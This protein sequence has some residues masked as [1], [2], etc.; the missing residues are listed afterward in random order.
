MAGARGA[1]KDLKPIL[2]ARWA[3]YAPADARLD[4]SEQSFGK[5]VVRLEGP[6]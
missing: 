5:T 2:A 1:I 4:T 6:P 3:D